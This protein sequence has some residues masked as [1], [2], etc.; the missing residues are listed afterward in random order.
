MKI[1]ILLLMMV[2]GSTPEEEI[3]KN[4]MT[5]K[6]N[7]ERWKL[8]DFGELAAQYRPEL[9]WVFI[10]GWTRVGVGDT[11]RTTTEITQAKWINGQWWLI[12]KDVTHHY[13]TKYELNREQRKPREPVS[14]PS[15]VQVIDPN[16]QALKALM[17]LMEG[18][19]K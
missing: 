8:S 7:G 1:K 5:I 9:S 6:P 11:H 13:H 2:L 12:T 14:E 4:W 16:D 19:S 3:Q 10:G 17:K 15:V 18:E